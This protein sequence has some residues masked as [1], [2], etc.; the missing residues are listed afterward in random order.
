MRIASPA[1]KE[2]VVQYDW[3]RNLVYFQG[4]PRPDSVLLCYRVL[5]FNLA[6][7]RF[8]RDPAQYDSLGLYTDELFTFPTPFVAEKEQVFDLGEIQ[9]SG[10]LTRGISIGNRQNAFVNSALNLQLEGKLSE[11]ISLLAN[12]S[13]Q[14][15]PFQPEGNTLQLQEFDRVF[16]Q[17]SHRL[18]RL[19]AGDVVL[20]HR[21]Q[22][23][24]RYYKNVQGL[25][26]EGNYQTRPGHQARTSLGLALSKG[27]FASVNIPPLEGVQGPYRLTGPNGE[28]FI[29]VLA[30]SEKV[31]IDG[32]E[33]T[34][35]FNYDY[36]IDYNQA[37]II[38]NPHIIITEFTRIR[39]DFEY[40]EQNYNRAILALNHAQNLGKWHIFVNFYQAA[41]NDRRPVLALTDA[42]KEALR[43]A[44]DGLGLID[45]VD[46][47]G[48]RT[49]EVLYARRDTLGPNSG[50]VF[51]E[52]WVYSTNPDEALYRV[53]FTELGPNQGDYVRVNTTVNGQIYEWR[54]PVDGQPQGNFAPVRIVPLPT[55]QQLITAGLEYRLSEKEKIYAEVALSAFDQNRFSDQGK[56]DDTGQAFKIGYAQQGKAW[57]TKNWE[58][59]ANTDLEINSLNFQPIDRFRSI[60]YDRDWSL[61]PGDTLRQADKIL[62]LEG[63]LRQDLRNLAQYRFSFRDRGLQ[64]NGWQQDLRLRKEWG[65]VWVNYEMFLLRSRQQDS[66]STDW[67][68]FTAEIAYRHTWGT[69]GY[70]Y[71]QDKNRVQVS[72][73][74][75]VLTSAMHFDQYQLYF[76]SPDSSAWRVRADF[77]WRQD[78]RPLDG[79]LR[80]GLLSQTANLQ[81]RNAPHP[82]QQLALT[83]S[84]RRL[85]EQQNQSLAEPRNNLM[86]RLDWNVQFWQRHVRSEL[87]FATLTGRELRREFVFLQVATG[88]G[89]HTWRDE[90]GDN[91]PDLN[92]FYL[93]INPDERQYI[94]VFTPTDAYIEAFIHTFNYRLNWMAPRNWRQKK[95]IKLFLSRFSQVFS[96]NINQR[97]TDNLFWSRLL[98]FRALAEGF[99]LSR[100]ESLRSALFFNR[101]QPAGG[102][103]LNLAQT[104]Q[105]QL[106]TNGFEDRNDLLISLLLR[107]NLGK[108]WNLSGQTAYQSLSNESD[109]LLSRN[110]K[111]QAYRF[112]PELAYQPSPQFRLTGIYL[113]NYKQSQSLARESARAHELRL[114]MRWNKAGKRN[115]LAQVR[116]VNINFDGTPNTPLSYELLEA[117]NPGQNWTW[118]LNW[119]QRLVNGLQLI[120][121]YDGR[122]PPG[123]ETIHVGRVQLTAFF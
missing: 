42:D 66:L 27:K 38:F 108:Q 56:A 12:I 43:Q 86:G 6:D 53:S 46:S 96:W 88:E 70:Q 77:T 107:K 35:G 94:K 63:G 64:V 67:Q 16:I 8:Q 15:V 10:S 122:R 52:I 24:L 32:R 1:P 57:G 80:P 100:Q 30:N 19:T 50:L 115:L 102:G 5:P 44:G 87:S 93:A 75:S 72:G 49:E 47:V 23:F 99:V 21:E 81:V 31:F 118:S 68:R 84:Y 22:Y 60:E 3:N 82:T 73:L 61:L 48:F 74:D 39:V 33:L 104:R 9:K 98:P 28:R 14:D 121:N 109:V 69:W 36:V 111:I 7:R 37:E 40:S 51:E 45:G 78:N 4:K 116:W 113:W 65:P 13:D 55:R 92:E 90:N 58:W 97:F 85:D 112:Q 110:F 105:K 25:W 41:D 29:I 95:G 123:Q 91:V 83:L 119:Q 26:L 120:L 79:Q 18:G 103:E 20:Q 17:L 106:L 71:Q 117:L 11:E 2:L 34:R 54:E 114:E 59:W 76:Q 101:N 62:N 89:T